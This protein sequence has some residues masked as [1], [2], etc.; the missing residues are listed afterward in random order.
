MALFGRC[1]VTV[2]NHVLL[3][4]FGR[5]V[6]SVLDESVSLHLFGLV[7]Q[8]NS[9]KHQDRPDRRHHSDGVT[10][11]DDAQPDGQRVFH[12]ARDA[13]QGTHTLQYT[14]S[15]TSQTEDTSM[16]ERDAAP[17]RDGRDAAHERVRRDAL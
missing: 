11:H 8:Q 1:D 2:V 3:L 7:V 17:E 12:R 6:E 9:H 16:E 10:E 13:T 4:G 14:H 15:T 5:L